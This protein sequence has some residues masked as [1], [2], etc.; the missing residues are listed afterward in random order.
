GHKVERNQTWYYRVRGVNVYGN[1]GSFSEEVSASSV[2]IKTTDTMFGEEQAQRLDELQAATEDLSDAIDLVEID[3]KEYTDQEVA[4]TQTNLMKEIAAKANLTYVDGQLKDKVD[5]S[6][7]NLFKDD[8]EE[9]IVNIENRAD[10]IAQSVAETNVRIDNL[11][12]RGTNFITHLPENW[13]QGYIDTGGHN[14]PSDSAIRIKGYQRIEPET[15]HTIA[16]YGNY[17]MVFREYDADKNT[18]GNNIYTGQ[19]GYLT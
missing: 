5:L 13:E 11:D 8:Y 19:N 10:G 14:Q 15:K 4:A 1:E 6:D 7:Y 2:K 16:T 9:T 17:E 12:I 3:Y 18:I